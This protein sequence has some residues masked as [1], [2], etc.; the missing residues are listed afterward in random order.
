MTSDRLQICQGPI[1]N[2]DD[3]RGFGFV[4]PDGGGTRAF[5]HI[6][7]FRNRQRRPVDGDVIIY[8]VEFDSQ[9]RAQ[10][11]N[12]DFLDDDPLL[13]SEVQETRPIGSGVFIAVVFVAVLLTFT[14]LK[15]IPVIIPLVYLVMSV[16]AFFAYGGDKMAAKGGR[17]RTPEST[18]Q[19]LAFLGG[20]PGALLGQ[21]VF[22]HK[23]R[24]MEFQLLFWIIVCLNCGFFAWTLKLPGAGLFRPWSGSIHE[25]QTDPNVDKN[26][27]P[28]IKPWNPSSNQ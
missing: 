20:W 11:V 8:D 24:K 26:Q 21:K 16:I 19:A 5:V 15:A 3:E 23:T 27:L 25:T 6:K 1:Q 18:L 10:A 9:N 22:R 4:E 14:A 17:W 12:I 13:R 7:A 2:W 28:R